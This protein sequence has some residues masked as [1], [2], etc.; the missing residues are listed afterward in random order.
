M[1]RGVLFDLLASLK[2]TPKHLKAENMLAL[3]RIQKAIIGVRGYT[4]YEIGNLDVEGHPTDDTTISI[5]N[6]GGVSVGMVSRAETSKSLMGTKRTIVRTGNLYVG[7]GR[8]DGRP[9][10]IVPLLKGAEGVSG[11]L[12]VHVDFNQA[13]T[14]ADK[15]EIL[16]DRYRDIRNLINE[17]NLP[18]D[19]AYLGALPIEILLGESVEF[20]ATKIRKSLDPHKEG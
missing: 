4:L 18:W 15:A 8:V 13:L 5:V 1:L 11:L 16:G 3:D 20:I 12:L 6:R 2:C 7:L 17:Y 14:A 10:V 9:L 19:D